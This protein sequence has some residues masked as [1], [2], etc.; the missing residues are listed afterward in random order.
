MSEG[1][2]WLLDNF[3]AIRRCGG[4]KLLRRKL[5]ARARAAVWDVAITPRKSCASPLAVRGTTR[6]RTRNQ[7]QASVGA[8]EP[9]APHNATR[10]TA[11]EDLQREIEALQ[12]RCANAVS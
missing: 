8:S 3:L 6:R 10:V 5:A 7:E 4:R 2:T 12:V 11:M 9:P 1:L